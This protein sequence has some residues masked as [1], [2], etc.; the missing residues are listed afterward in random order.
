MNN[1]INLIDNTLDLLDNIKNNNIEKIDKL[2]LILKFLNLKFIEPQFDILFLDDLFKNN[3]KEFLKIILYYK[4]FFSIQN[5]IKFK[6]EIIEKTPKVNTFFI[7]NGRNIYIWNN[8]FDY[9]EYIL[10]EILNNGS[11]IYFINDDNIIN[12][13]NYLTVGNEIFYYPIIDN[14]RLKIKVNNNIL[15][16]VYK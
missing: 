1:Y 3:L 15:Y 5:K 2:K 14:R 8:I 4:K 9:N 16:T 11:K 6:Y 10:I 12:H 13:H 7:R